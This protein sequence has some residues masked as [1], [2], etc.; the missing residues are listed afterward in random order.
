MIDDNLLIYGGLCVYYFDILPIHPRPKYLET[1][2]SYI[3]RLA[4]YNGI[5][6]FSALS[7]ILSGGQNRRIVEKMRDHSFSQWDT[8]SRVTGCPENVLSTLTFDCLVKKFGRPI[9][10]DSSYRFLQSSIALNLRYCPYCLSD[11]CFYRLPWRFLDLGGCHVH[12]CRLLDVCGFCHRTM[13]LT[14]PLF[15]IGVC[16]YCK[17]DLRTCRSQALTEEELQ[18]QE[19]L[20]R[21]LVF[22]LLP[23]PLDELKEF[24]SRVVG[25][26]LELLRQ[27]N[28]LS[29]ASMQKALNV[30]IATI[31]SMEHECTKKTSLRNYLLYLHHFGLNFYAISKQG[32]KDYEFINQTDEEIFQS[33]ECAVDSFNSTDKKVSYE[34]VSRYIHIPISYLLKNIKIKNF[35]KK[36]IHRDKMQI[37]HNIK[38]DKLLEIMMD[39]ISQIELSENQI[40]QA[41]VCRAANISHTILKYYPRV[42]AYLE[43]KVTTITQQRI[44]SKQQ[45]EQEY[46]SQVQLII[47][48]KKAY[49]QAISIYTI[50]K[51]MK[52]STQVLR[53][54][55]LIVSLIEQARRDA[56][57]SSQREQDLMTKM[58]HAIEVLKKTEQ[59]LTLNNLAN[60]VGISPT[61]LYYYPLVLDIAKKAIDDNILLNS[62]NTLLLDQIK[63][64]IECLYQEKKR[65]T[66]YAIAR[67]LQVSPSSLSHRSE[68]VNFIKEEKKKK[69][70]FVLKEEMLVMQIEDAI[71]SL[72]ENSIIITIKN[73]TGELDRSASFLHY[74]PNAIEKVRN[75]IKK[76]K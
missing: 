23:S 64:A 76:D 69:K 7:T 55:P 51:A 1:F 39:V 6:K 27:E 24:F 56:D 45:F 10:S 49:K 33:F 50:G 11:E 5:K 28:N 34:A 25:A 29:L 66:L 4:E 13:P 32:F 74:Y 72:R 63:A 70:S 35:M 68:I 58:A 9:A 38:E 22:L 52:V 71:K 60:L 15:R 67:V 21:D 14:S 37:K 42:K 2:T 30:D 16:P 57:L 12:S 75:E 53:E 59:R 18:R 17:I 47:K 20:Y 62:Q 46:L 61:T 31:I 26:K 43:E 48:R 44:A 40:T 41:V 19:L 3:M 73:V 36:Y 8:I 54:Y 65:I